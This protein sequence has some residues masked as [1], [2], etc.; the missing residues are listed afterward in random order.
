MG[1]TLLGSDGSLPNIDVAQIARTAAGGL[2]VPVALAA[3]STKV[4]RVLIKAAAA[5][6]AAVTI[7]PST[8]ASYTSLAAGDEYLLESA[9]GY[10]FNLQ[11]WY[12][13][14]ADSGAILTIIYQ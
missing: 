6:A 8:A 4:R 13:L 3:A 12:M 11:N 10:T 5:N 9:Q 2:V 7:G 1:M 14:S